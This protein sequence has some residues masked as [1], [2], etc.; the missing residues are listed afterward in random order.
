MIRAFVQPWDVVHQYPEWGAEAAKVE[1]DLADAE[2]ALDTNKNELAKTKLKSVVIQ[3]RS[4]RTWPGTI[5][6]Y[7][8]AR[9]TISLP[10]LVSL[11]MAKVLAGDSLRDPVKGQPRGA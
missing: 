8:A 3:A 9:S 4:S 1:E 10:S 6:N 11:M 7:F 2:M 5:R